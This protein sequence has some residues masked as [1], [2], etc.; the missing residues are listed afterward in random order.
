MFYCCSLCNLIDLLICFLLWPIYI[1]LSLRRGTIVCCVIV[2]S[3]LS[4]REERQGLIF[5]NTKSDY[6]E[7]IPLGWQLAS[8][9]HSYLLDTR[10][11]VL[12]QSPGERG[13]FIA[14]QVARLLRPLLR[15]LLRLWCLSDTKQDLP[16]NLVVEIEER[17]GVVL[18][19][20]LS[21]QG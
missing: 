11:M 17:S 16:F 10:S 14:H 13:F 12:W 3:R 6:H 18:V 20:L 8:H 5:W 7:F 19:S 4:C 2:G 9:R 15:G 21:M 1:G